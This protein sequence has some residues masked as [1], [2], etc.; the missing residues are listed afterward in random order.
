MTWR[1]WGFRA[2]S[3]S[4]DLVCLNTFWP[5]LPDRMSKALPEFLYL[6]TIQLAIHMLTSGFQ[7]GLHPLQA[8]KS[9]LVPL[10]SPTGPD[11]AH[12]NQPKQQEKTTNQP[13]LARFHGNEN[14]IAPHKHHRCDGY[15]LNPAGNTPVFFPIPDHGAEGVVGQHPAMPFFGGAG[16][17]GGGQQHERGCWQ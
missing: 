14:R 16:E 6:T 12:R 5:Y 9:A 7:P 8:K 17:T 1:Y 2:G 11:H 13:D 4:K 3:E 10:L 15:Q